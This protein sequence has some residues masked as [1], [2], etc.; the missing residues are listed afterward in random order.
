MILNPRLPKN[1]ART[2]LP[3]ANG[4]VT[5]R[6]RVYADEAGTQELSPELEIEGRTTD[7][8]LAAVLTRTVAPA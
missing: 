4:P 8:V 7:D 5:P 2:L 1:E 3:E 6:L